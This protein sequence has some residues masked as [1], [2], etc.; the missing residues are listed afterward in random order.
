MNRDL[1]VYVDGA[2]R[3]DG[4]GGWGYVVYEG[5][6]EL[7]YACGGA[8]NT[9]NN[10]MELMAAIRAL[11]SFPPGERLTVVSDSKYVVEGI[12]TYM[13]MWLMTNWRTSTNKPVKNTD[14][15]KTLGELDV[16]RHVQWEWVKG[17]TGNI[18][19]ERA[20]ELAGLGV[21]EKKGMM[22]DVR[23]I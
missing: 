20:D 11:R 17:H 6:I 2:S 14:L 13:D 10:R 21:P 23:R 5:V 9:T 22:D 12:L 19:N 8:Y 3:K 18:G 16:D 7:H 1:R 15:W 4:R